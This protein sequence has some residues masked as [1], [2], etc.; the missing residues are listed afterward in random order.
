MS[1]KLTPLMICPKCSSFNM[2]AT[3]TDKEIVYKCTNYSPAP[4]SVTCD[5][6]LSQTRSNQGMTSK[7]YMPDILSSGL[8]QE[9]KQLI[10]CI[11]KW[12]GLRADINKG[13]TYWG[14]HSDNEFYMIR[15]YCYNGNIMC[16]F[17]GKSALKVLYNQVRDK[18]FDAKIIIAKHHHKKSVWR[19]GMNE[20]IKVS[21]NV[22]LV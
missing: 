7:E 11:L 14:K 13:A 8:I 2:H 18:D 6:E 9:V 12:V 20:R 19:R 3:I 10:P 4:N 5:Y 16:L 22:R 15:T 1:K 21:Q 17:G